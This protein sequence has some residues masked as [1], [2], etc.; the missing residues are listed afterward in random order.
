MSLYKSPF[1][2]RVKSQFKGQLPI[3][4]KDLRLVMGFFLIAFT[5]RKITFDRGIINYF[6]YYKW[7]ETQLNLLYEYSHS[8]RNSLRLDVIKSQ[9]IQPT[10]LPEYYHYNPRSNFIMESSVFFGECLII[11]FRIFK[12]SFEDGMVRI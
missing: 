9:R 3:L 7:G 10:V 2:Q 11:L 5:Y 12:T 1:N 4:Y 6:L 8:H